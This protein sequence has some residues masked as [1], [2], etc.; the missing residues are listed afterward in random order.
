MITSTVTKPLARLDR[1]IKA[2]DGN[3]LTAAYGQLMA[4]CNACHR[5]TIARRS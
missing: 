1:A 2:E 4:S 5:A 3:H